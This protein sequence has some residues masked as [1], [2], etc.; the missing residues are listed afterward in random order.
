M[1]IV[2]SPEKGMRTYMS[3]RH[4]RD[5]KLSLK[6]KGLL[7][8]M[9]CLPPTWE[10]SIAGLAAINADGKYSVRSA[11]NELERGGY[12]VRRRL[13]DD[14]GK[15][16]CSE[17]L[18][19]ENPGQFAPSCSFQTMENCTELNTKVYIDTKEEEYSEWL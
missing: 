11:V 19:Y 16:I 12:L 10:F 15:Y 1:P 3:N 6:A 5:R 13:S 9:L 4:L 14:C 2:K 7:S 8:Q 18:L 17:Y